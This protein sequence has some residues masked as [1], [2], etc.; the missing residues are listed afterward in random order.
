MGYGRMHGA[1][2][3]IAAADNKQLN[4]SGRCHDSRGRRS[5]FAAGCGPHKGSRTN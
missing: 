4:V 1:V 5:A 3:I 2:Y